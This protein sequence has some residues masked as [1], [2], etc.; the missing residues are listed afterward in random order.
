MRVLNIVIFIS[1]L[2][3]ITVPAWAVEITPSNVVYPSSSGQVFSFDFSISDVDPIGLSAMGFKSTINVSPGGLT[4]DVANSESVANDLGYWIYNNNAGINVL[5]RGSNNYEF[6]D[7]PDK[8]NT[9]QL[10]LGDIMARYAFTWDGVVDDYT[11][12]LD[13]D[14]SKSYITLD[15]VTKE[16]L[17]L[18]PG[19]YPGDTSSFTVTV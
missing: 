17:L 16:A 8:P 4:L 12:T 7:N 1:A 5:D 2:V 13:L 14:T 11:F 15:Y 10:F 18:N 6:A 3:C 9:E 19:N